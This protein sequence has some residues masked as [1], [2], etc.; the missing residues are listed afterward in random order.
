MWFHV[1]GKTPGPCSVDVM[2]VM[3]NE[4][5]EWLNYLGA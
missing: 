4:L 1:V 2:L 5:A 3:S